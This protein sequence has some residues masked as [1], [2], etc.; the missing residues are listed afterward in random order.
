MGAVKFYHLTASPMEEAAQMLL[1]RAC[2]LGWRVYLRGRDAARLDD[3]DRWLWSHPKDS[4]LPHGREGG[5]QDA[6][7]PVLLGQGAL[8]PG[9]QGLM[10]VDG[11]GVTADEAAAVDRIWILFDGMDGAAL[12]R[13]RDQWRDLTG[14]G[15]EAEYWAEDAGRWER[16]R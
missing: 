2:D 11:A 5:P 3:L 12:Q 13:A 1:S 15:V 6:R 4:F 7:Q 16:K 9:M 10:A 14:A 8:P